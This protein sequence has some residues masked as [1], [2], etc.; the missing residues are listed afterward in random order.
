MLSPQDTVVDASSTF[1]W[2]CTATGT[3][4]PVLTWSKDGV[5][6]QSGTPEHIS[7]LPNNSLVI[8]GVKPGD[9]GQYQCHAR[10]GVGAHVVQA[11]LTVRGEILGCFLVFVAS[12][13]RSHEKAVSTYQISV[14]N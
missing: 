12:L 3:P 9:A 14:K 4:T 1:L 13:L 2:D 6:F 10:N 5:N 11:T 7:I 8:T